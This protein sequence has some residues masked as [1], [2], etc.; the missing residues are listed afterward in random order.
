MIDVSCT[1]VPP[2]WDKTLPHALILAATST[3]SPEPPVEFPGDVLH[4]AATAEPTAASATHLKIERLTITNTLSLPA[5]L[6]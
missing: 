6:G 2:S 4:P 5:P 3:T 1:C